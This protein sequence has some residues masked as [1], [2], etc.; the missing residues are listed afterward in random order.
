MTRFLLSLDQA[1]DTVFAALKGAN[2][3]EIYV[4]NA[5]SATVINIAKALIAERKIP[6]KVTGI[7]PGEKMHEIMVSEEE[8]HHCVKRGAY[9]AI[10]P[11]LPEL[12]GK[13][14]SPA[15]TLMHEFSS[16]DNVLS[17]ANTVK[18]LKQH[19]LDGEYGQSLRKDV[20]YCDRHMTMKRKVMTIVGTRPEIIKLSRVIAE[21]DRHSDHV[22][23]HTG[24]N[25]DYELNQ[26]FSKSCPYAG[27]I[28]F[29]M[30]R[31]TRLPRP[32]RRHS[33]VRCG[34]GKGSARR[35][36]DPGRYQFLSGCH[37][38]ETSQNSGFP[39]GSRQPLLR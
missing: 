3:G 16:A 10:T 34:A 28:T 19:R 26:V 5:P 29:S 17:L 12:A 2:R 4:P 36:I 32:S 33:E 21:L 8:I 14:R 24:Q 35:P 31:V 25:Y 11:M 7:R 23:V 9:Y 27:R 37:C 15:N 38:G 13:H 30:R 39:Y 1:V 22:L 20:N 18:L 6:T